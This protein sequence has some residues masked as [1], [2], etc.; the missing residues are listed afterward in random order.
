[1]RVMPTKAELK[2]AILEAVFA[3]VTAVLFG[4]ALL[5]YH[6]VITRGGFLCLP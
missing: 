2:R 4:S 5:I 3:V 6:D 1:M